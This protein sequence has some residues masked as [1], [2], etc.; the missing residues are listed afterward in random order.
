MEV[1]KQ[2]ENPF[3]KMVEDL[4]YNNHGYP[5]IILTKGADIKGGE[6]R[7]VC[8]YSIYYDINNNYF[9]FCSSLADAVECS[10]ATLKTRKIST[11]DSGNVK[12][13]YT[14]INGKLA[15]IIKKFADKYIGIDGYSDTEELKKRL[16]QDIDEGADGI[17]L[18]NMFFIDVEGLA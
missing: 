13:F 17:I 5:L 3:T 12:Y 10:G 4:N 2:K 18:N 6:I 9:G 7:F 1:I 14:P 16:I 11:Y 15:K 8:T